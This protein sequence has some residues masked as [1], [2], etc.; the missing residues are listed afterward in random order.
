MTKNAA[1][2]DR[3]LATAPTIDGPQRFPRAAPTLITAKPKALTDLSWYD[4]TC[5]DW[6]PMKLYRTK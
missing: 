4:K 2:N 1:E 3:E 6:N 5:L